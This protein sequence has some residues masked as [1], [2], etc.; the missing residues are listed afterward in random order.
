MQ[1]QLAACARLCLPADPRRRSRLGAPRGSRAGPAVGDAVPRA[2]AVE[3]AAAENAGAGAEG[4]GEQSGGDKADDVVD[5]EFE[6]VKD[7]KK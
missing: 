7:D 6:E 5:A 2:A 3:P 4:G 1:K